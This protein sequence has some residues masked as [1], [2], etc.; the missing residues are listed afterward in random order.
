MPDSSSVNRV[1]ADRASDQYCTFLARPLRGYG[2]LGEGFAYELIPPI[3][4]GET[5]LLGGS[6][7]A[8]R[9]RC[10]V[11]SFVTLSL[12]LLI[13]AIIWVMFR[14]VLHIGVHDVDALPGSV[15]IMYGA[16]TFVVVSL[17]TGHSER[18]NRVFR[19]YGSL[20][21]LFGYLSGCGI[22]SAILYRAP[23]EGQLRQ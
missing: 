4:V 14:T 6:E 21:L 12:P 19:S 3:F 13:T 2:L 18:A 10:V 8:L 1:A 15:I 23:T 16:F 5:I 22:G 7:I 17:R 20:G 11:A 9:T